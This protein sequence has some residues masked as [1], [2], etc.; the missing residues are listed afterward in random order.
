VTGSAVSANV[1]EVYSISDDRK[2][3]TIEVTRTDGGEARSRR[4]QYRP[5]PRI[6]PC[7]QWPTPCKRF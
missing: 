1:R 4:L 7:E 5:L 2:V 3:L 6:G